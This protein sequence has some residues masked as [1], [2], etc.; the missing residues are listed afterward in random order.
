MNVKQT[1]AILEFRQC[2]IF[3]CVSFYPYTIIL[4]TSLQSLGQI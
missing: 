4:L 1:L 2:V 3:V